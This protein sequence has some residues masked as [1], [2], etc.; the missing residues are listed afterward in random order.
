MP[1]QNPGEGKCTTCHPHADA[2]VLWLV[3][4]AD[5]LDATT[6]QVWLGNKTSVTS[7]PDRVDRLSLPSQL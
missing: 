3:Q 7:N 5:I 4:T 2:H 1:I 6:V